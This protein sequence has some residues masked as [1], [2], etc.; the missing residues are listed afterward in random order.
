VPDRVG[1]VQAIL[2]K[3]PLE[4]ICRCPF[5]ASDAGHGEGGAPHTGVARFPAV[6]VTTAGRGRSRGPQGAL[7]VSLVAVSDVALGVANC[8]I[9]WRLLVAAR[10]CLPACLCGAV[11]DHLIVGGVLGGSALWLPE[12]APKE[13]ARFASPWALLTASGQHNWAA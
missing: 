4:M 9:G 1:V 13:V 5:P 3:K 12:R 2:F 7:P 8:I 11:H 10:G 6:V